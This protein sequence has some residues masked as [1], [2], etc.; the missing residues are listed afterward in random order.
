MQLNST[1]GYAG[2]VRETAVPADLLER[3]SLIGPAGYVKERMEA[4]RAAGVTMLNVRPVGA[5]PLSDL[6]QL[7]GWL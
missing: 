4:Y 1:V 2:D 5:D 7:R 3:T 6:E